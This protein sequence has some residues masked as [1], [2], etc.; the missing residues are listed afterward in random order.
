M[1]SHGSSHASTLRSQPPISTIPSLDEQITIGIPTGP[2]GPYLQAVNDHRLCW[3][4]DDAVPR[5]V[6]G[7]FKQ[8]PEAVVEEPNVLPLHN[9]VHRAV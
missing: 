1:T 5:R 3:W 2:E 6:L 7:V 4:A 8:R 9:S